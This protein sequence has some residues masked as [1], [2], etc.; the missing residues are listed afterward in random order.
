[1]KKVSYIL[2]VFLS[3]IF[4][5]RARGGVHGP[6]I[7]FRRDVS[8]EYIAYLD[9]MEGM[10]EMWI[11]SDTT[12]TAKIK[13]H[14]GIALIQIA[15]GYIDMDTTSW[16]VDSLFQEAGER[17]ISSV[18]IA[19]SSVYPLFETKSQDE[20][21]DYLIDF[22]NSGEYE[23]RRD[24]LFSMI[25]DMGVAFGELSY[26]MESFFDRLGYKFE[27]AGA[28]LDTV[29]ESD[30]DF[31]FS[32]SVEGSSYEDSLF[33]ISRRFLDLLDDVETIG[34]RVDSLFS[35]GLS[36]V[37]SI[38]GVKGADI[39][40]IIG[41][42][43]EGIAEVSILIDTV[44]FMLL[45]QPFSPLG[46]DISSLDS[47]K[48][49]IGELD[50]LLSGK[51]YPIGPENEGK[52]IK[53]L[54]ILENMPGGGLSDVFMDFYRQGEQ[55]SYTFG[56]IFPYGITN[57]M[58]AMIE[59]D[60]VFNNDDSREDFENRLSELETE[61]SQEPVSPDDHFG[62]ALVKLYKLLTDE[63]IYASFDTL[64]DYLDRGRIDSVVLKYTWED[65]DYSD[66]IS[67]IRFHINQYINAEEVTNFVVLFKDDDGY[68]R[69]EIGDTTDFDVAFVTVPQVKVATE[70]ISIACDA[71]QEIVDGITSMYE[72]LDRIFILDLDPSMLDFSEVDSDSDLVL[73]FERANPDFL[74]LTDYGVQKFHEV[75]VQLENAFFELKRFFENMYLLAQAVYPYQE[76]F[77]IDG[78]NFI[79]DTFL[80]KEIATAV[81]MDFAYP[82]STIYIDG[83]RV[84]LSAWFDNPPGSLLQVWKNYVF[85]V[86][87]TLGGIF[88]DRYKEG[89]IVEDVLPMEYKLSPVYPNPFNPAAFIVFELPKAS[90]V[91]LTIVDLRGE[92]V[93]TLEN[94]YLSPGRKTYIWNPGTLPSGTY[95][96]V[97]RAGN[98]VFTRKLTLLK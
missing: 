86:D 75:G 30:V 77:S 12:D 67:E 22:F 93:A 3:L 48:K 20:F 82:D 11:R 74:T 63:Q 21:F 97:L 91:E 47:L 1:M 44:K 46:I 37:D 40:P 69:Y 83:E 57:D 34:T 72:E 16:T 73:V 52:V 15:R 96:C 24:S 59:S 14:V 8:E 41:P 49:V 60:A 10:F 4:L 54:A 94:S 6:D 79:F 39:A 53:P 26:S 89:M 28:H 90:S 13:A 62:I 70:A 25:E 7:V 88:P 35:E 66:R 92:I 71:L 45:S 87:S 9:S 5:H 98:R 31:T 50:E 18:D 56:G 61:W 76:D 42:V 17:F 68:E 95:I 64:F 33:V 78:D 80:A 23:N 51:E 58:Y 29:R 43:R 19:L 65:F 32:F 84:N 36:H 27:D 2:V 81:W 85:G 55:Q 38:M